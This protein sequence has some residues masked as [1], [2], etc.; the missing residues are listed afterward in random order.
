MYLKHIINIYSCTEAISGRCVI[1]FSSSRHTRLKSGQI[2]EHMFSSLVQCY[3]YSLWTFKESLPAPP[4]QQ[5]K[6]STQLVQISSYFS[7]WVTIIRW[8]WSRISLQASCQCS[9][10][11]VYAVTFG[12]KIKKKRHSCIFVK[13]VSSFVRKG[14]WERTVPASH[15]PL[16]QPSAY[17]STQRGVGAQLCLWGPPCQ[18]LQSPLSVLS[19]NESC[20][21]WG[22]MVENTSVF[23]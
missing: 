17:W 1:F 23:V 16:I 2:L 19:G 15:P 13:V 20:T 14:F 10:F 4:P 3:I 6:I 9:K 8:Y 21:R 22:I 5:K 11:A 18:S 12:N 7:L